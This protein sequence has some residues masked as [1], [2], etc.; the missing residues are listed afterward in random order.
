MFSSAGD[1]DVP[2][3]LRSDLLIVGSGPA[4]IA[5]AREF[6]DS[7]VSVL[8]SESGVVRES[9][10]DRLNEVDSVGLEHVGGTLG[11]SRMFGG[12]GQKWVGQCLRL[13][14]LDFETR[15]W[16]PG[17][18]WPIGFDDLG[19]FYERADQLFEVA[20]QTYDGTILKEM[21]EEV[22]QFGEDIFVSRNSVFSPRRKMGSAFRR[23]FRQS[24]NVQV[25]FDATVVRILSNS[26]G[27]RVTGAEIRSLRGRVLR[28]E[29]DTVV[30]CCGAIENARL[31]LASDCDG[32][33]GI[34]NSYGWVGRSYQDH[35]Y[36]TPAEVLGASDLLQGWY[37]SVFRGKLQYLPKTALSPVFQR[38]NPGA[39]RGRGASVRTR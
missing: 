14:P 36:S 39:Q 28:V 24:R 22:P 31:L 25:L 5:L 9:H 17:S 27:D 8:V 38:T 2:D 7:D 3:T 32:G 33:P 15:D 34:G 23:T 19:P 6:L 1:N 16:V 13:D 26:E 20:G 35:P 29:C 18:G 37:Q 21:F 11:R 4:G 30:L 12:A 10:A